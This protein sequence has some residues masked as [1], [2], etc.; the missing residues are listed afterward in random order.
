MPAV[1]RAT[2]APVWR[3]HSRAVAAARSAMPRAPGPHARVLDGPAVAWHGAEGERVEDPVTPGVVWLGGARG[4]SRVEG[5]T[6]LPTGAPNGGDVAAGRA[7]M[8]LR[9]TT[10]EAIQA[11]PSRATA[12]RP[13]AL[14]HGRCRCRGRGRERRG[15]SA[16]VSAGGQDLR[17]PR[18]A[19]ALLRE[20]E[21]QARGAVPDQEHAAARCAGG[22]SQA[23][24]KLARGRRARSL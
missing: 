14:L 3:T 4:G 8:A 23:G 11:R 24:P 13:R 19:A 1:A 9:D 15:R 2:P 22:E 20:P 21:E 18:H 7:V 12:E 16:G 5:I 17:R 6:H 10:L